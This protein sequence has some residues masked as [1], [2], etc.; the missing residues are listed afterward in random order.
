MV[1]IIIKKKL[2]EESYGDS[3]ENTNQDNNDDFILSD[4]LLEEDL[5]VLDMLITKEEVLF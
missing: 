4:I 2:L 3:W 5:I 1:G